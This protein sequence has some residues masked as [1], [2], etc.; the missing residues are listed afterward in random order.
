M[1]R[2]LTE[3]EESVRVLRRKYPLSSRR[4][5]ERGEIKFLPSIGAMP[6]GREFCYTFIRAL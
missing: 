1:I 6:R 4:G 3:N 2:Q 5:D